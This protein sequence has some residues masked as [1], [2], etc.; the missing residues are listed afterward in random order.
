MIREEI[1]IV[2]AGPA[3]LWSAIVATKL[4][5][6]VTI[7]DDNPIFGGQLIK[8]THKFFGSKSHY[9]G[10]RG[11][12]IAK[13]LTSDLENLPV[14]KFFNASVIG[15]YDN[16]L[17]AVLTQAKLIK[18]RA[19]RIIF[20]TGASENNIA[21][22]NNDL[23]GVYGAGAVQTLMNVYGVRPGH[24]AL[25]VGSGN[26]G[27][28]VSYQMMQAN[29]QV[30]AVLE[31]M[32]KIGGYHVHAAKLARLGVPILTCYTIK[33]ALGIDMVEGAVIVKV[34]KRFKPIPGTEQRLKVD[35]ICL[36]VGLSPLN[37]LL[38]QAGCEMVY[39]PELGGQVAQHNED[40]MTSRA[41]IFVGGDLSG[42]EEA[43]TA[44]L[45]GKI[46]GASAY[47]SLKGVSAESKKIKEQAKVELGMIRQGPF[48]EKPRWGKERLAARRGWT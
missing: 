7:I 12:N 19:E 36:A 38:W 41:D 5:A 48:G 29:I 28:I 25:M 37:E 42:I 45:E 13:I 14:K 8:Q 16:N 44:M 32:P 40:M 30:V 23:P 35:T 3:G 2:G 4:G 6:S 11:I 17:L 9:C 22:P 15:L 10:I 43:S 31:I 27:L 20:A 18:L 39:V 24:R 21:F 34:N 47:E 26:I 1:V 33:R 46:A